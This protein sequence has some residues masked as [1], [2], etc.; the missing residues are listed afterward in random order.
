[1]ALFH[2]QLKSPDVQSSVLGKE[3]NESGKSANWGIYL[4]FV[5]PRDFSCSRK[6]NL[7]TDMLR[8]S[9]RNRCLAA[10]WRPTY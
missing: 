5:I 10:P 7:H 1:V 4:L 2:G 6:G 8:G 3:W 9:Q